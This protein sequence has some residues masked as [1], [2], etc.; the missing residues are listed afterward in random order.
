MQRTT[1]PQSHALYAHPEASASLSRAVIAALLERHDVTRYEPDLRAP[2]NSLWCRAGVAAVA[3]VSYNGPGDSC[4]WGETA[5]S[6]KDSQRGRKT[7]VKQRGIE[8]TLHGVQAGLLPSLLLSAPGRA[9]RWILWCG[10]W[11]GDGRTGN[12]HVTSRLHPRPSVVV[13]NYL[14]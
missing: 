12:Q 6:A 3:R 14:G 2:Q 5:P 1:I 10:N 13:L 11:D 4:H 9:V 7:L 8:A